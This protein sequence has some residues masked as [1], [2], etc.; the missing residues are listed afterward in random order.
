MAIPAKTHAFDAAGS[1]VRICVTGITY[2]T[3]CIMPI[4]LFVMHKTRFMCLRVSTFHA[5]II[6]VA[7]NTCRVR[8][9]NIMA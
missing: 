4:A 8:T 9:L 6:E 5:V 2:S 7:F 1:C 3:Q